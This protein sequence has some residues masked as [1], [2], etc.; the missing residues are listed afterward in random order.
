MTSAWL[1]LRDIWKDF[2]IC[3]GKK[4]EIV[5]G[6][7]GFRNVPPGNHTIENYGVKL[8]VYLQPGEVKVYTLDS[9]NKVFKIFTEEEDDFGFHHLAKSGAMGKALYEWPT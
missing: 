4:V 1:V 8:E 3:D 9:Q 5:G 2:I 6:F 7:R